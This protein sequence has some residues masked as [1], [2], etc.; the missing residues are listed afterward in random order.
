MRRVRNR[1]RKAVYEEEVGI[2]KQ[3]KRSTVIKALGCGGLAVFA[4]ITVLYASGRPTT[5]KSI[6]GEF[7][8]AVS[9]LDMKV[10]SL[11]HEDVS[12][13]SSQYAH[14]IAETSKV[15]DSRKP[16]KLWNTS[17]RGHIQVAAHVFRRGFEPFHIID[18]DPSTLWV[19]FDYP[20]V[21]EFTLL[22][23]QK[24]AITAYAI[25]GHPEKM[26]KAQN[27][28]HWILYGS[29]DGLP[30]WLLLDERHVG[31]DFLS[32]GTE[33]SEG[34]VMCIQYPHFNI[35]KIRL[36][37]LSNSGWHSQVTALSKLELLSHHP[38]C[39]G[40]RRIVENKVS[41][42]HHR[43]GVHANVFT[44]SSYESGFGP[45][46][47]DDNSASTSWR[48][49][50]EVKSYPHY[51]DVE[52]VN[53]VRVFSYHIMGVPDGSVL[54]PSFWRLIGYTID[55]SNNVAK[56]E[57]GVTLDERVLH[58][59]QEFRSSIKEGNHF[60]IYP[61]YHGVKL[62]KVRLLIF[63]GVGSTSA[64]TLGKTTTVGIA[65]FFLTTEEEEEESLGRCID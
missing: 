45:E 17:R 5:I 8:A 9:E 4:L 48:T 15:M 61:Q 57:K 12:I 53:P 33:I 6:L 64:T 23:K 65:R 55:E 22:K 43:S 16:W 51:L 36:K 62:S 18:R 10:N 46:H 28:S 3:G 42:V 19:A 13:V 56:H 37:I 14:S 30:P 7:D 58:S 54:T 34:V 35:Q 52:F 29:N 60:C 26:L 27:P 32:K 31:N 1:E 59:K 20:A 2:L 63:S 41:V 47:V 39:K 49:A 11:V 38:H 25:A 40:A 21:A 44:A 24:D 50:I